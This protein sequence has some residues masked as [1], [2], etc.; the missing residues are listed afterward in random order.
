MLYF[1]ATGRNDWASARFLRS[2]FIFLSVCRD[3][4]EL[5]ISNMLKMPEWLDFAKV[6]ASYSKVSTPFERYL[7][8]PSYTYDEQMH[9]WNKSKT[10]P[11]TSLKT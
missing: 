4:R 5:V 3:I 10:Y 1:T 2:G 9:T 7:S 11:N 8:N 6:R